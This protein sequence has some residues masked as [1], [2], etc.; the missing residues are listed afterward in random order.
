MDRAVLSLSMSSLFFMS[1]ELSMDARVLVKL[2]HSAPI[3]DGMVP[4]RGKRKRI[5]PSLL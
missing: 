3:P 4:S 5:F 2:R 1:L